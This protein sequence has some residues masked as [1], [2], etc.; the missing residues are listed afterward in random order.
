MSQVSK[1]DNFVLTSSETV[2]RLIL[3]ACSI[4]IYGK[5]KFN[6]PVHFWNRSSHLYSLFC[7]S[8]NCWV[9]YWNYVTY[10]GDA[11]KLKL[12]D[13][14]VLLFMESY[15]NYFFF[16][17]F[18][19]ATNL[20]LRRKIVQNLV[21]VYL[22]FPKNSTTDSKK[23]SIT[24]EW[25]GGGQLPDPSLNSIFNAVLI[26]A[27]YEPSHSNKLYLVFWESLFKNYLWNIH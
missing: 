12:W 19:E 7:W 27:Q 14:L 8:V 3:R 18:L 10:F 22:F 21:F 16:L 11:Q 20:A 24:L 26:G 2:K 5:F 6:F 25:F 1:F 15:R 9:E 13:L 4:I 23:S 17:Y